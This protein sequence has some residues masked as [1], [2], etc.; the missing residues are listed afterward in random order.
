MIIKVWVLAVDRLLKFMSCAFSLIINI[1]REEAILKESINK[2]EILANLPK[3]FGKYRLFLGVINF[4]LT[5]TA[6][7][8]KSIL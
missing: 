4:P 5:F 7:L 8:F 1:Y 6:V 3:R 2:H